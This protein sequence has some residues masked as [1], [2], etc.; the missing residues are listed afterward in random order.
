MRRIREIVGLPVL[1]LKS[2]DSIGWVQD[3]VL[4]NDK[5]EVIGILLEGGHLF[6]SEKGIPRKAIMTVG[7]DALTVSSKTV[8]ELKG[9]RWSDKVGNEVYTQGGDARGTIED[10]FL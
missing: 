6:R 9:T 1:D 4:D 5:D 2:G 3:L 8:E 7:K 10:V